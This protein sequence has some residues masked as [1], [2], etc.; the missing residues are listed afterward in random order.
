M[1]AQALKC[2]AAP[3]EMNGDKGVAVGSGMERSKKPG[4]AGLPGMSRAI[5][6]P[7]PGACGD[8]LAA[9]GGVFRLRLATRVQA[10]C[11]KIFEIGETWFTT[12][13]VL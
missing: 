4:G 3:P 5:P 6:I 12:V 7:M 8:V 9:S 13:K 10:A 1:L 2:A 11:R